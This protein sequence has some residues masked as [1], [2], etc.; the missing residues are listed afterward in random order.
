MII[1]NRFD[2]MLVIH[3]DFGNTRKL[4]FMYMMLYN[5]GHCIK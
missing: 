5:V 3:D 4:S 1:E 2:Q